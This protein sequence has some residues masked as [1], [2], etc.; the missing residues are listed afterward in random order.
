MK[1]LRND[2][3]ICC[4][5]YKRADQVDTLR[6]L[7][8]ITVYVSESE[9]SLYRYHNQ[10]AAAGGKIV[11]MPDKVQGNIARVRNWILDQNRDRTVCIVDD[12]LQYVGY[13]E[14][15][16]EVKLD[17]KMFGVFLQKYTRIAHELGSPLWGINLN[18]DKQCYREYTPFSFTSVVLA[19]FMV[20][21]SPVCRFDENIPLKEDYDFCLQTLNRHRKILRVNKYHYL[22]KQGGAKT[23]LGQTGG[24]A[25]MRSLD[26]ERRQLELLR[27]KWGDNIVQLDGLEKSRSHKSV[28]EKRFDINPVIRIPIMGV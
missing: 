9:A 28:K 4:P 7:R 5:S 20:H 13:F 6:Y 2:I 27:R 10:R 19:P 11:A 3:L 26:E 24:C 1:S 18:I 25:S 12:D 15:D 8:G 23:G 16:Q 14:G 21:I 17:E 22:T